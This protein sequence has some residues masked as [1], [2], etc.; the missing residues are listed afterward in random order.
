MRKHAA[1]KAAILAFATFFV[2]GSAMAADVSMAPAPMMVPGAAPII[3]WSG[4]Y[5]GI[6]GGYG[7]GQADHLPGTNSGSGINDFGVAGWFG[8][9][10]IGLNRQ[11]ASNLV[12]GAELSA[13]WSGINGSCA[14]GVC[15]VPQSTTHRIDWFG[16]LRGRV[17][18]AM[19]SVMPYVTGG[20]A[21][22]QA[23]RHTSSPPG[24]SI[25]ETHTGWTA[26]VGVEWMFAPSWS[27]KAEYQYVDLG[28]Q[29]YA[30]P[31]AGFDPIV[32]L[33]ANIFSIGLNKHF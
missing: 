16:T 14:A 18:F 6:N 32:A 30:Y 29:R 11:F 20:L 22:G 15:G 26:G 8:G 33:T 12:L 9:G 19:G 27:L 21:F 3:N 2:A 5:A 4:F 23:T 10:Q 7:T 1:A 13:D 25:Q 28:K 17:G 24:S 31:I